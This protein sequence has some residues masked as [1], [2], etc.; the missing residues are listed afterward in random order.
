M[1]VR[2]K[3]DAH[4]D[5]FFGKVSQVRLNANMTQNVVIYTVIVT[6]ENKDLALLPYMSAN[7]KFDV[8]KRTNVLRVPNIAVRWQPKPEQV[9]S[10]FDETGARK[11]G[12]EPG[13]KRAG[14][15]PPAAEWASR[16]MDQGNVWVMD[17]ALVRPIKVKI[18][19]SDGTLTE[20]SGEGIHEGLAV[21]VGQP[22]A[23]AASEA[24]VN[25]LIPS[26]PRRGRNR[27]Q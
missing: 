18:G 3:V 14:G 20:I 8:E 11:D 1:P 7:V 13:E 9:V 19:P 25:P 6:A 22:R 15:S 12:K 26:M 23:E 24:V 10:G 5:V 21:V 2:F 4:A 17:G 27:P 16:E